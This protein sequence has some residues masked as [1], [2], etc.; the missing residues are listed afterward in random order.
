MR[1]IY[2]IEVPAGQTSLDIKLSGGTGDA[3]LFVKFGSRPTTTDYDYRPFIIGNSESVALSNPV[4]G[5]WYVMI[6]GY[7]AYAGVTLG[8]PMAR[9]LP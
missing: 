8:R 3:D 2:R 9:C 7:S 6:R 4:A 1:S 5:T